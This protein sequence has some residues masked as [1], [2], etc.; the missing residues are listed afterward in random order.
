MT[1][2]D[3]PAGKVEELDVPWW[4]TA[5]EKG[6]HKVPFGRDLLIERGIPSLEAARRQN[7]SLRQVKIVPPQ[8]TF[9]SGDLTLPGLRV[10]GSHAS[11]TGGPGRPFDVRSEPIRL[12]QWKHRGSGEKTKEW[13]Y[14]LYKNLF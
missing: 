6:S 2:T 1:L 4:P 7:P 12:E 14:G 5:P 9:K 8:L 13:F 11:T 3:W 10:R